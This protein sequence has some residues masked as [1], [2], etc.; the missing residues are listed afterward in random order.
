MNEEYDNSLSDDQTIKG[1]IVDLKLVV[2]QLGK[3]FV[4]GKGSY[5]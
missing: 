3:N 1:I 2:D 4:K 5:T